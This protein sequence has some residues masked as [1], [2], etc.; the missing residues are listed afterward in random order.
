MF[1]GFVLLTKTAEPHIARVMTLWALAIVLVTAA[2][3]TARAFCRARPSYLQRT[4]IL[5]AG[6]VGQRAARKLLRHPE[7]GLDLLGFV[8]SRPKPRHDDLDQ[9]TILGSPDALPD[10]V[11]RYGVERPLL[12]FSQRETKRSGA[13]GR[14]AATP[15]RRPTTPHHPPTPG[16]EGEDRWPRGAGRG[17]GASRPF[18]AF[19]ILRSIPGPPVPSSWLFPFWLRRC[20]R[21]SRCASSGTRPAR[22]SSGKR[23]WVETRRSSPR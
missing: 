3:S 23:A 16:A 14:P 17:G 11:R 1:Y 21:T 6:D 15:T 19:L 10:L 12:A 4:I 22:S 18:S 8:D 2:R 9:L 13:R 5:G 7:Y 20:S